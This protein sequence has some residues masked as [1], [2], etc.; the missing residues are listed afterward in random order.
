MSIMKFH[1]YRSLDI[2]N[3]K[4]KSLGEEKLLFLRNNKK[5][6]VKFIS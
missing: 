1:I 3:E 5:I 6:K 2:D 4:K